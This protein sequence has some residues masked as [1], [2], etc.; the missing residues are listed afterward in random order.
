MLVATFSLIELGRNY[1]FSRTILTEWQYPVI[2]FVTTYHGYIFAA[3]S[4]SIVSRQ[5]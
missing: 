5:V 1:D 3:P 2:V 4:V